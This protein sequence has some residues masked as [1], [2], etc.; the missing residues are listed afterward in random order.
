VEAARGRW[1]NTAE[2]LDHELRVEP[3][4]PSVVSASG[5]DLAA[6]LDNLTENALHYSPAGS[7]VTITWAADAETVRLAVLDEGPGVDPDE[8]ERVF[9][10]FYRGS[11]SRGGPSGT[12]LGLAVVESLAARWGGS[13]ALGNQPGGGARAEVTLPAAIALQRADPPLDESLPRRG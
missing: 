10:R 5:E 2:H 4:E 3:G 1:E 12:G 13:V 7:T 11:A 8:N 9:Q 6:I